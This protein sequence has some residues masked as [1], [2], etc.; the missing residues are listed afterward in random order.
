MKGKIAPPNEQLAASLY[1][2]WFEVQDIPKTDDNN[3]NFMPQINRNTW[4][5]I[6][7]LAIKRVHD[8]NL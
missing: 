7:D 2:A 6:A 1:E 4:I 5:A 8:L 3:W